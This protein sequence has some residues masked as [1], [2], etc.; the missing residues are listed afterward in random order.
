MVDKFIRV[1]D[2][3]FARTSKITLDSSKWT[4]SGPYDQVIT[5]LTNITANS[6]IDLTP[7]PAQLHT[8]YNNGQSFIIENKNRLIKAYCIG[9]RPTTSYTIS[10]SITEVTT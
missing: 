3:T 8:L 1:T 7:T 9:T 4:G 2:M 5:G 10:V 6:K